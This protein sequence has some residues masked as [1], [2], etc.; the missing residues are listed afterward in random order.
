MTEE[1]GGINIMVCTHLEM[2]ASITFSTRLE[3]QTISF[4]SN[5]YQTIPS[6][7]KDGWLIIE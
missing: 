4:T 6:T 3:H 1:T 2:V 7:K 5:L